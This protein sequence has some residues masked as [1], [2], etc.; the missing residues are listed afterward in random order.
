MTIILLW[1]LIV[2]L[3]QMRALNAS[4]RRLS[5]SSQ[6]NSILRSMSKRLRSSLSNCFHRGQSDREEME[7]E[8]VSAP[9]PSSSLTTARRATGSNPSSDD[10]VMNLQKQALLY[11][12]AFLAVYLFPTIASLMKQTKGSAPFVIVLMLRLSIPLQG[13]F[14]VLIYTRI[15]IS[16]LRSTSKVSWINA[17]WTVISRSDDAAAV[18]HCPPG[19]RMAGVPTPQ[20]RRVMVQ[21]NETTPQRVSPT[22][23]PDEENHNYLHTK[24][25]KDISKNDFSSAVMQ[26][27]SNMVEKKE[28]NDVETKFL[29]DGLV[30]NSDSEEK[31]SRIDEDDI[32]QNQGFWDES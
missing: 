15:P 27:D 26:H 4:W 12:G 23:N 21:G 25:D 18:G 20:L 30:A 22:S 2:L 13:F 10:M 24:D 16:R 7:V 14:N 3:R 11:I 8:V 1:N 6:N 19:R 29:N 5:T 9:S 31:L 32:E 17:F 28:Q